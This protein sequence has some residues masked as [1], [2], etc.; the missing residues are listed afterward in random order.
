MKGNRSAIRRFASYTARAEALVTVGAAA[1]L[2]NLV[3]AVALAS[4]AEFNIESQPEWMF[5]PLSIGTAAT[6][7]LVLALVGLLLAGTSASN[8]RPLGLIWDLVCFLPRD[9]HPLAPPCYAER[10]VPE[11]TGR[12]LSWL[13]AND[14]EDEGVRSEVAADRRVIL[15]GHSLGGVLCVA[16]IMQLDEPRWD[17]LSLM[18]YGSQ[19]QAYFSRIFPVLLGPE[20]LGV[21]G[22][23]A[24][25][26]WASTPVPAHAPTFGWS[27]QSVRVRL[28]GRETATGVD[29]R[30]HD[31]VRWRNL[32]RA[33][34]PIGFPVDS[35]R[36][37]SSPPLLGPV[38]Y[39]CDEI[40]AT[41]YM[42]SVG[43]HSDYPRTPQYVALLENL[44]DQEPPPVPSAPR[45]PGTTAVAGVVAGAA[46]INRLLGGG[47]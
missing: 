20:V 34:D 27:A 21:P 39:G 11:L 22:M 33:T 28:G 9:G 30:A 15:S 40:D 18:T 23:P 7:V 2:V 42:A 10:A 43:G 24:L 14:V 41:G 38:D 16:A 25:T 35:G 47:R 36:W 19:L 12:V 29:P 45:L 26:F 1:I 8:T 37:V 4:A 17:R 6:A 3:L 13:D 5:G 46:V 31:E 32:W 44:R